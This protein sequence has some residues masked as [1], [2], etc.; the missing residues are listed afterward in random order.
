M[1][2]SNVVVVMNYKLQHTSWIATLS[3]CNFWHTFSAAYET[4]CLKRTKYVHTCTKCRCRRTVK[5]AAEC[6]DY[7]CSGRNHF[8]STCFKD[9]SLLIFQSL[10][11]PSAYMTLMMSCYTCQQM[12]WTCRNVIYHYLYIVYIADRIIITM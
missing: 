9:C 10:H 1:N 8:F 3:N 11:C 2:Q 6:A 5:I 4:L 12:E 7:M